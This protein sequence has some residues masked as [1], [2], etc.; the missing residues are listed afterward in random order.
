MM[1]DKKEE[2]R[3][4]AMEMAIAEIREHTSLDIFFQ[5]DPIPDNHLYCKRGVYCDFVEYSDAVWAYLHPSPKQVNGTKGKEMDM[6]EVA[7]YVRWL[8]EKPGV[9]VKKLIDHAELPEYAGEGDRGAD[10]TATSL[11]IY[12][13]DNGELMAE[14]GTGIA[15]QYPLEDVMLIF[16][17]SS[18]HKKAIALTNGVGVVDEYRGEIKFI[19]RITADQE[20]SIEDKVY[21]P[22]ERIGQIVFISPR[23]FYQ[24]QFTWAETLSETARGEGGFGSTGS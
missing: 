23:P 22:G 12:R 4:N 10:I 21:K 2:L 20:R 8:K 1:K 13:N 11:Q 24:R 19:F 6:L 9:M 15:L 3:I 5:A 16:P 17:R 7:G 14:Y 18:V